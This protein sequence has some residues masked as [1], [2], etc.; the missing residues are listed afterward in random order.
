[1]PRWCCV[2]V[3]PCGT[4]TTSDIDKARLLAVKA[5]HGSEWIFALPIS[6]YGIRISNEDVRIAIALRLGLSICEPRYCP[7]GEVVDAKRIHGLSCKCSAVRSIR[8][9][10]INDRV[11]RAL[12]RADNPTPSIK[13]PS[14]LLPVEDKR[15][16]GLTL[17]PWHCGRCLAWDATVVGTLAPFYVA[18]SPKVTGSAAQAAAESNVSK[19]AG[20]PASR[21]NRH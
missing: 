21:S 2:T 14:G 5:G 6:A 12:R 18:V 9:Q 8:H 4:R 20:L 19:Y 7:C 3:K 13:E 11:W 16:D 10:Q 15:P 17:V 1:M